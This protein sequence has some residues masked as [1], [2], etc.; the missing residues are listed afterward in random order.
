LK[1]E[2]QVQLEREDLW[3]RQRAKQEWLKNGDK[4]THFFH[5]CA[6]SRRKKKFIEKI[7]DEQGN[8]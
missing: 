5:A 6:N 4:N 8:W 1:A 3:W 2:I 7:R